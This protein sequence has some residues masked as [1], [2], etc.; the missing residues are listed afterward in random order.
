MSNLR[1]KP[2]GEWFS[3]QYGR[4][5]DREDATDLYTEDIELIRAANPEDVA[6]WEIVNLSEEVHDGTR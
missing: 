5:R 3:L 2:S 4:V 6:E 1:H